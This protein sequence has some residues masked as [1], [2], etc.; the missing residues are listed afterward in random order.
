MGLERGPSGESSSYGCRGLLR[1]P[2]PTPGRSQ[3]LRTLAAGDRNI[4]KRENWLSV[5]F[6]FWSAARS[7]SKACLYEHHQLLKCAY[8][9]V[10]RKSKTDRCFL[11]V[12]LWGVK[13][14]LK[15]VLQEALDTC[16]CGALREEERKEE[17]NRYLQLGL[18]LAPEITV[19]V[20][21][22][23]GVCYPLYTLM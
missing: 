7:E 3:P 13:N 22:L 4:L 18:V 23:L 2:Q 17:I 1:S 20:C 19:S 10:F 21:V 16:S 5:R 15:I 14:S 11:D 12:T 8:E 9:T 6:S